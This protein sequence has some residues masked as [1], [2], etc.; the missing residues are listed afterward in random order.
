[1]MYLMFPGS[2]NQTLKLH[3]LLEGDI[4]TMD[5]TGLPVCLRY[6]YMLNTMTFMSLPSSYTEGIRGNQ[7][8]ICYNYI[9][10]NKIK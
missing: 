5:I 4:I 6:N 8:D 3:Y 10:E 2:F 1:M 9:I 7:L